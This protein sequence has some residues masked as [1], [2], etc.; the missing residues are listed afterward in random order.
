MPLIRRAK[1]TECSLSSPNEHNTPLASVSISNQSASNFRSCIIYSKLG[2]GF[3]IHR[4]LL[5][6]AIIVIYRHHRQQSGM[7]YQILSR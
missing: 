5:N 7:D 1:R 3:R 6:Y 4:V 2:T